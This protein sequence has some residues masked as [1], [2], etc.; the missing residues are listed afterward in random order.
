MKRVLI[1]GLLLASACSHQP[2]VPKGE[3]V[4]ARREDPSSACENLGAVEG[5]NSDLKGDVERAIEDLKREAALKGGNYVRVERTSAHGNS[6]RGT[7][8]KCP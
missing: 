6:V 2:L 1:F 4:T 7:V 8:F 5:R 3:N